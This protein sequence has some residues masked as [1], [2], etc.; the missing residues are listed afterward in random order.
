MIFV[1]LL[2]IHKANFGQSPINLREF[3]GGYLLF[4]DPFEIVIDFQ[5]RS[6]QGRLEEITILGCFPQTSIIEDRNQGMLAD[7][8]DKK[9]HQP[10]LWIGRKARVVAYHIQGY[11]QNEIGVF[12]NMP[13]QKI[14]MILRGRK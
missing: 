10:E 13:Q 12:E 3:K 2:A 1:K 5:L 6:M 4:I 11:T 9:Y 7:A 8:Y 14:S